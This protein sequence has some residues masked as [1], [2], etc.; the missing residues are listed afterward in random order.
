MEHTKIS[1]LLNFSTVSKFLTQR[2]IEVNDLS[3][4]WYSGNKNIR[5]KTSMLRSDS[6]DYSDA[7]IVLKGTVSVEGDNDAKA[8]TKNLIFK[9][10][11]PFRSCISEI[12]NTFVDN[13]EYLDI[14][15]PIYNLLEYSDNY[16]MTSGNLR[17]YYRDEINHDENE[18]DNAN[19]MINNDKITANKYFEYK[20]KIMGR[21]PKW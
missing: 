4:N 14:V 18:I 15:M 3:S 7:Y 16:S 17:N 9:N 12:N 11:A 13:A 10:N 5:F 20:T 1:K 19:N 2:W 6:C 8:K 21:I